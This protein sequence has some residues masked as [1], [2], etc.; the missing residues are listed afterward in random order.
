MS[1]KYSI[2]LLLIDR[3]ITGQD[4]NSQ[5]EGELLVHDT[6]IDGTQSNKNSHGMSH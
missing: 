3:Y 4:E 2:N 1:C 5:S 6:F